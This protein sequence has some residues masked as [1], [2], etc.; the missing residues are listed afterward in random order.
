MHRSQI[1]WLIFGGIG[2]TEAQQPASL[3]A[4]K[5][6]KEGGNTLIEKIP[7]ESVQEYG[8]DSL[9]AVQTATRGEPYRLL[10]I[11]PQSLANYVPGN[12]LDSLLSQTAL[13]YFPLLVNGEEKAF[14]VV[15]EMPGFPCRV[16]SLGYVR[17]ARQI[18][19]ARLGG[20]RAIEQKNR[21]VVVYQAHEFFLADAATGPNKLYSL[22]QTTSQTKGGS[23][24]V[25]N[26]LDDVVSRLQPVVEQNLKQG[27]LP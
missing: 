27:F 8:F 1:L 5:A 15:E 18:Q 2:L 19:I 6:V 9:E 24:E 12:T 17:L 7:A 25:S 14:L 11:S 26:L 21:L 4:A 3:C 16:V 23:R 10:A 13:W 20:S 22:R